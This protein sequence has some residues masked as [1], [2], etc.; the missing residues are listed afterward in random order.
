MDNTTTRAIRTLVSPYDNIR[1]EVSELKTL[2]VALKE[3]VEFNRACTINLLKALSPIFPSIDTF[4]HEVFR[5][6]RRDTTDCK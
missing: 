3:E 6:I 4:D 1:Q 2:V 5:G